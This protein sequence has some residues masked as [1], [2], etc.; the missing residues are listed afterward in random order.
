MG[1]CAASVSNVTVNGLAAVKLVHASGAEA[2][3]YQYAA[4]LA[5]WKTADGSEQLFM[6]S[7]T[8][9]GGGKALRGG[10]PVCW[11]QF[12]TRGPYGKHGFARNTDWT[13]VRSSSEPF[14][15]VVLGLSGE[16]SDA[17]PFPY[18]LTYS[19]S[20]DSADSITTAL[21]V[22]NPG[23]KPLEFT[24]VHRSPCRARPRVT[25]A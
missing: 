5:S 4:H 7:A 25:R 16:A 11:P 17:F 2:L 8:A 20:L 3:V 18:K 24:S 6:S 13:V 1:E 23:E 9:Y 22:K 19:V 15:T 21:T 14:P 10:I 12:N